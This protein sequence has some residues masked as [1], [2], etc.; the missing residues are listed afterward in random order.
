M[1]EARNRYGSDERAVV[2]DAMENMRA[3]AAAA[4]LGVSESF[5][6]KLRM[7]DKRASGPR[8]IK[9]AGCVIYRRTDLDDW[10]EANA[11]EYR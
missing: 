8:F 5:L 9:I 10:L 2:P 7:R 3:Q 1:A 4:Y 6:A 11:I